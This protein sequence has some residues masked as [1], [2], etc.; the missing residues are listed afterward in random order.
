MKKSL[1]LSGALTVSC[2]A[3]ALVTPRTPVTTLESNDMFIVGPRANVTPYFG[4]TRASQSMDFS[5]ADEVYTFLSLPNTTAGKTNAYMMF[6]MTKEDIAAFKGNKVT[7]FNIYSP[8][9][10]KGTSNTITSAEVYIS[11]SLTGMTY[12]QT[13]S[14]S[15]TPQELN[16]IVLDTPYEITGNEEMLFFGYKILIPTGAQMF[17]AAVDGIPTSYIESCLLAT[18]DTD[19]FP[20]S[21]EWMTAA[22]QYGALAMSITIEGENLPQN[23]ATISSVDAPLYLPLS[24][25][26]GGY[27]VLIRNGAANDVKSVE[28]TTSV[29]GMPDVVKTFTLDSP[30]GYNQT[31]YVSPDGI[32][33]K[34]A[35]FT[36]M[37]TRISKVNGVDLEST[38]VTIQL[39]AYDNGYDYNIVAEDATGTWCPWCPRG[40]VALEYMKEKYGDRVYGIAVHSQDEMAIASYS[41]WMQDYISSYPTLLFNRTY[42]MPSLNTPKLYDWLDLVYTYYTSAPSYAKVDLTG[43]ISEN[44]KLLT[45]NAETEFAFST[46]V[47][48]NIGFVV[49][50]DG[51]GPYKQANNY[52]GGNAGQMGGWENKSLN[53]NTTFDD[54][55]RMYKL[56]PGISN[57]IPANIEANTPNPCTTEIPITAVKGNEFRVIAIITNAAT[58]QVVNAKQISL[59]KD[60]TGVENVAADSNVTI[61]GGNGCVIV[62]GAENYSVYTTA[63]VKI[64]NKNLPAGLYIVV[65]EGKTAKV[66]V[67]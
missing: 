57:G 1:L 44:K 63:G 22:T 30:L 6:Q 23:Y 31:T 52:S 34:T 45:V 59:Q 60:A 41:K 16:R 47:A 66:V 33:G 67:K 10:Q 61:I 3:F 50:E 4:Q 64:A 26:G 62:N 27:D 21:N 2:A 58:G 56:Y 51:L 12:H 25:D 36:N 46:D 39:P 13:A 19:A 14:L 54:V 49:V 28:I 5:Y 24:G 42:E 7:A 18:S 15:K 40:T 43:T 32:K 65:A 48:H 8:T 53:V 38:P 37:S 55:A 20:A 29:E 35:G 11:T 9:D 17:Y